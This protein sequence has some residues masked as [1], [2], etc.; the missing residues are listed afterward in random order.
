MIKVN[1]TG[2]AT[3]AEAK[4]VG[5]A[6]VNSPLFK[7]AV[8]GNDPNV[9]RLASSIGDYIGN[10]CG[11]G[12][13]ALANCEISMGGRVLCANGEFVLDHETEAYLTQHMKEAEQVAASPDDGATPKARHSHLHAHSL[14]C[15]DIPI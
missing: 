2:G 15:S 7:C 11:G 14:A 6:V 9:G 3:A 13:D 8:A 10:E 5:K 1:V 12:M 4:G